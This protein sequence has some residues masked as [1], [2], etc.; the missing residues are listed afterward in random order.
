MAIK[1]YRGAKVKECV[2][3]KNIYKPWKIAQK[4]C[5]HD[6]YAA[7]ITENPQ[8]HDCQQCGKPFKRRG[9]KPHKYCGQE[10]SGLARRNR[11][12]RICKSCG[13]NFEY[14]TSQSKHY[15]NAGKY[16]SRECMYAGVKR[17]NAKKP[18]NP[19]AGKRSAEREWQKAVREKDDYTCQ[20]CYKKEPYIHTHHIH[21]RGSRPDLKF[22]VS[23]GVCL[24]NSC[25][26]WVHNNIVEAYDLGLIANRS[27]E[28]KRSLERIKNGWGNN[29]YKTSSKAKDD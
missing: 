1:R 16:C 12:K 4:Y 10:C 5:S 29:R 20:K 23:N 14:K 19:A 17:A 7:A 13:N 2:Y 24:C 21:T 18:K 8:E 6:C 22:E 28:Y 15:K 3:C 27:I 25:H 11:D 26:S 9:S